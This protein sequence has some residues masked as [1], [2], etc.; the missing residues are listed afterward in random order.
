[1][2]GES[3]RGR[4]KLAIRLLACAVILPLAGWE[5]YRAYGFYTDVSAARS[6]LGTLESGLD[7]SA[8]GRNAT[9]LRKDRAALVETQERL[10]SAHNFI[11]HDPAL[12]VASQLP[13][14]G[15][16]AQGLEV[17]VRAAEE[18]AHAGVIAADVA[19]AFHDY[20]AA[21]GSTS[22]EGALLF[23]RSQEERM[24]AL[25]GS[26]DA[27]L[28]RQADLPSGLLAPLQRA[29]N[30]FERALDKLS[31]LVDGY[32]RANAFLPE[33]LGVDQPRKYLLLFQNDTELFPSGG[34]ISSYGVVTF[35][36]ARIAEFELEY[37][38]TLYDRWQRESG[39]EYVEPP[40]PLKRYLKRDFSWALGEAGWYPDFPTTAELAQEFVSKGGAA[41][42]KGTIAID[43]QFIGV[44]L[45]LLGPVY[46]PEYDITVTRDNVAEVTLEY[47]RSEFYVPGEPKKAFLSYMAREVLD[48][49][50]S[51]PKASWPDMLLLLDRMRAER[52]LQLN[53]EDAALQGLATAYGFDG[54]LVTRPGD[55]LLLADTSV[56]STK[57]N[58]I[59]DVSARIDVTLLP[60]GSARSQVTYLVANPFPEWAKGRDPGLVSQLMGH[61]V[62]G[63]YVRTY[64]PSQARLLDVRLGGEPAGA[65]QAD[66][67]LGKAVFGRFFTV[68]PGERTEVQFSYETPGILLRQADGA[69]L[70][71]LYL[72][73]QA[74]TAALPVVVDLRLP[75]GAELLSSALDGAPQEATTFSTDL[76][77]DREIEIRFRLP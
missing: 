40:G 43:I 77:V 8:L 1:M 61:G 55:F 50:F 75:A 45:G 17:L 57:L 73:K 39:G 26:L 4:A 11:D 56:N 33:I 38:G 44:L 48:G 31:G 29:A 70:Y 62:Y 59:L 71:S 2:T 19:L 27:L 60:E 21:P 53:F 72:Q 3:S 32:E 42:T 37:F 68:Q 41:P 54:A 34:L 25:G 58:L 23:M 18:S 69:Y 10:E 24:A 46:V 74:G 7:L 30:D 49:L 76:R 15:K 67:E 20:E 51:V 13:W 52:H 66:V 5:T 22:L 28:A 16:Q 12:F 14:I 36:D 35:D 63:A 47:T 9:E 64:V 6:A 65:E